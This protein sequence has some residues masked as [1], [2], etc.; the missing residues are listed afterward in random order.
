[1]GEVKQINIKN[2]TYYFYNDIINIKNF[3][4]RLLKI[5][6]KSYKDIGIYNI[7]YI[8]KK[9][10]DNYENIYGVNPLYLFIDHTSGYIEVKCFNPLYVHIDH[11]SGYVEEKGVKKYF[12]FD[13]TDQ[14]KKLLKKYSDVW[15][16]INNKINEVSDSEFDYEKDY[17][18]IKFNSDDNLPLNK[19]LKFHLMTITIRCVFEE[20]G[21]L[22][23]QVYVDDSLYE[24]NV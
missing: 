2:R 4:G 5:D 12:V 19:P 22:Y 24:I 7:G 15:N 9:K 10:I 21:K 14:N 18:K 13:T 23:P 11:V 6:K 1:M 17:M 3:D 20:D 8:T 16:G